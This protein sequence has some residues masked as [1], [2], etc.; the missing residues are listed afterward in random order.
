M[1]S[2]KIERE[3]PFPIDVFPR[4]FKDL[5]EGLYTTLNFPIDYTG[6]AIL[7]AVSSVIGTT[8]K[9]KVRTGWEEYGSLYACIIGNA[10]ANKS[11]PLST[12]FKPLKELDQVSHD[13][14]VK[15]MKAFIAIKGCGSQG[16]RKSPPPRRK[17]LQGP[18]PLHEATRLLHNNRSL[19]DT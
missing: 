4:M 15:K 7:S 8:V 3:N 12:I 14:Y 11:H 16:R 2:K 5:A 6:T 13:E 1:N 19:P 10:G 18:N 9:V 17:R